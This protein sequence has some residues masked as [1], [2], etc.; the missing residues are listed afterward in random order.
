M[1]DKALEVLL[2]EAC[3]PIRW[4]LERDIL[5]S[6]KPE[7][8]SKKELAE[9]P[10]VQKNLDLLTGEC[11]F[12][13]LH[14]S[15]D[16]AFENICGE[17]HDLG[18]CKDF[19][20][21]SAK[22]EPYFKYL[23]GFLPG[24]PPFGGFLASLIS[25]SAT[26]IGYGQHPLVRQHVTSRLDYLVEFKK[27][28]DPSVFYAPDPSDMPKEWRGKNQMVNPD[29]YDPVRGIPLPLIH[30]LNSWIGITDRLIKRKAEEMVGFILSPDYQE[31]IKPGFGTVKA[32]SRRYYAMGWSVHVPGWKRVP[33]SRDMAERFRYMEIIA[34]FKSARTHPWFKR[35]FAWLE[36]F[37]GEDGLC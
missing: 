8:V 33:D 18:V 29:F 21:L 20:G 13:W 19:A 37:T 32:G 4:R 27:S 24:R 16:K 34:S 6:D 15:L 1:N 11:R 3:A 28:F 35:S 10:Q 30:D 12:D 23:E 22:L 25:A 2:S 31:R 7:T 17:L 5:G 26:L 14:S 36:E 9:W